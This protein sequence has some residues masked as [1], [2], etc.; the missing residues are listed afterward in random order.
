M[1]AHARGHRAVQRDAAGADVAA[2]EAHR[3]IASLQRAGRDLDLA[4]SGATIAVDVVPVVALLAVIRAQNPI[5]AHPAA[6]FPVD[7]ADSA[8]VGEG[9]HPVHDRARDPRE[10]LQRGQPVRAEFVH[11][12]VHDGEHVVGAGPV[13]FRDTIDAEV[14]T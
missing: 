5:A 1:L 7:V 3:R 6:V 8:C 13:G 10:G 11:A 2:I 14:A 9:G 12:V 4:V